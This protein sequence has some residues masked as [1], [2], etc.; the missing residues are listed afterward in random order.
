MRKPYN[1]QQ[2]GVVVAVLTFVFIGY[3]SPLGAYTNQAVDLYDYV[4]NSVSY[5]GNGSD[6][7][8]VPSTAELAIFN[9][10][11]EHLLN[12]EIDAAETDCNGTGN[13]IYDINFRLIRI[14]DTGTEGEDL[15]CL[16]E[17]SL[18]GRGFFCINYSSTKKHHISAPHPLFEADTDI[19]AV[20]VMRGMGARYISIS[21][22][23]RCANTATSSCDGTTS[24]CG[25]PGAFRKSDMAHNTDSF[26]HAFGVKIRDYDTGAYTV[27]LHGCGS[28]SCPSSKEA[29]DIVAR[30]SVGAITNLGGDEAVNRLKAELNTLL[31]PLGEGRVLSCNDVSDDGDEKLCGTTNTL[32]RYINGSTT[33]PCDV[34][35]S[36]FTDSRFLHIE[37]N[38][39]LRNNGDDVSPSLLIEALN[40]TLQVLPGDINADWNVSMIDA[41]LGLQIVSKMDVGSAF[42]TTEA[43]VDNNHEI[44]VPEVIYILQKLSF[45]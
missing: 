25:G 41:V 24:V 4:D 23:H 9:N 19:E 39:N 12:R 2:F 16:Q 26:F 34:A 42:I 35:G 13:D 28:S 33:D 22:T 44:G 20:E 18:Q 5:T 36:V 40:A 7:Y 37:Q 6:G 1:H 15:Y 32:G 30:I 45:Q 43:D 3:V 17:N 14:D 11:L 10:C 8:I 38:S 21:T 27:Q 31:L 29:S